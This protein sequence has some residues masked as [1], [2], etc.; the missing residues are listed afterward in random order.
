MAFIEQTTT[1]LLSDAEY[2]AV[3]S[4]FQSQGIDASAAFYDADGKHHFVPASQ[5]EAWLMK[6]AAEKLAP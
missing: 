5:R 4:L 3:K 6:I 1:V 2:S